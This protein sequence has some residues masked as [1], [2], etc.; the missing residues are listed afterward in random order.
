MSNKEIIS[1]FRLHASLLDLHEENEWKIKPFLSA[2]FQLEKT[3]ESLETKSIPDLRKLGFNQQISEKI[4]EILHLGTFTDLQNLLDQ[5]PKGILEVM[6]IKGLGA[7]KVRILWKELKIES[8]QNLFLACQ[9]NK[10]AKTKGFGE[11]TQENILAQIKYIRSNTGKKRYAEAEKYADFLLDLLEKNFDQA[12]IT[13]QIRRK[14]EI[15]DVVQLVVATESATKVHEFLNQIPQIQEE[16]NQSGVFA[17]RGFF[18]EN[19]LKIEVKICNKKQFVSEIF[20]NSADLDH[21]NYRNKNHQTLLNIAKNKSFESESQIYQLANL[22]FIEPELREAMFE[23]ELAEQNNLPKL[24]EFNDLK[25]SLHNH[26]TYSDGKNTLAQMA[27][28]CKELGYEYLGIA[29]HSKTAFYANGLSEERVRKQHQE[30]EE[31]N[32]K[33]APFKILKGIESDILNDGS[34][35]Y[36]DEILATFDF[37]VASVHSNL[38]MNEEKATQRLLKAISNPYTTIL[39]HPTGRLLLRREGYP[40]DHQAVIDAC[41]QHGVIIEINASPY[42]LD[43][44]W[45]WVHYAIEKGVLLSINPDAHQK[46]AYSEMYYGVLVGRKGGLQK[47]NTFNALNLAEIEAFL[48]KRKSVKGIDLPN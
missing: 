41:A 35:D 48:K 17:W 43:L 34:L 46:E 5:T 40:I 37:V 42:R 3:E 20:V 28:Y 14:L 36:S 45:R 26:S 10:V 18:D 47:E 44:D 4:N 19:N 22:P 2:I 29:D 9:E 21:L 33:L 24:L 13:G 39:G 27:E 32:A 12:L 1:L 15:V 23:F 30:I 8:L 7:K 25:G 31:L 6:Q 38:N 11:K 16:Q